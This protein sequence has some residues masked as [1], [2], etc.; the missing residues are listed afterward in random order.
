MTINNL[1]GPGDSTLYDLFRPSSG[2]L[3]CSVPSGWSWDE[4]TIESNVCGPG[5]TP[6]YRIVAPVAGAW[7][8]AVPSGW[9]YDTVIVENGICGAG[10]HNVYHLA[11]QPSFTDRCGIRRDP[12]PQCVVGPVTECSGQGSGFV[13]V[14]D[15]SACRVWGWA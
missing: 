9:A 12:A 7:D 2:A 6:M 13:A 1:C 10:P 4:V 15:M 3:L 5:P 8:Y 11:R 14:A